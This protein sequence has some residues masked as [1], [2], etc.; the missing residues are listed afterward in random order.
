MGQQLDHGKGL[1][2]KVATRSYK[3]ID[4]QAAC[5]HINATKQ[6]QAIRQRATYMQASKQETLIVVT[7]SKSSCKQ[8]NSSQQANN[9]YRKHTCGNKKR[10]KKLQ[11]K[12]TSAQHQVQIVRDV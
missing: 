5:K 11:K 8:T 6:R 7:S 4:K 1:S 9:N 10:T 12:D 2:A 3:E